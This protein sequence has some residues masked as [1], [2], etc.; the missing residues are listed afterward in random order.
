M[1]IYGHLWTFTD[2]YGHFQMFENYHKH[3]FVM[4]TSVKVLTDRSIRLKGVLGTSH[5]L[6]TVST[7]QVEL[8]LALGGFALRADRITLVMRSCCERFF[9]CNL[10]RIADNAEI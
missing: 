5:A 1:D 6:K 7:S 4:A 9:P 3:T 2:I 10:G 8:Y